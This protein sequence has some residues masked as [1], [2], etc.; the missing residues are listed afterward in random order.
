MNRRFFWSVNKS[1]SAGISV[2]GRTDFEWFFE[3]A[4]YWGVSIHF[5]LSHCDTS[6]AVLFHYY[7]R[8]ASVIWR[9]YE[10]DSL[11]SSFV[12]GVVSQVHTKRSHTWPVCAYCQCANL[13]S[14][15]RDPRGSLYCQRCGRCLDQLEHQEQRFEVEVTVGLDTTLSRGL[16]HPLGIANPQVVLNVSL[17]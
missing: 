13:R 15:T 17:W 1:V 5:R 3:V 4:Y 9:L 14:S 2:T 16:P 8:C 11:T 12:S 10:E 6:F 7:V